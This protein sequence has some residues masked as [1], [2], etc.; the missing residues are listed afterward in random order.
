MKNRIKLTQPVL[1]SR[2]QVED[3]LRE[4]VG[5][6]L[7]RN[8]ATLEMDKAITAIRERYEALLTECNKSIEEKTELVRV[9]AEANPEEFGKLKSLD[10]VH[11]IIGFRTGT[12]TLKTITGWTWDRVLEKIKAFPALLKHV[13]TKEEVNKQTLLLDRETIGDDGLRQ[14]GLKVV[15][16]ESFFIEPKLTERE[17]KIATAATETASGSRGH[18]SQTVSA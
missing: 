13:R 5:A 4:I 2:L 12:P 7:N 6:T 18:Q 11:A 8:K 1:K 10:F 14:I 9:W 16:S 17:N 3:T 15:Q